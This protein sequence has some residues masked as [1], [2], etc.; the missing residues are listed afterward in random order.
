MK[1]FRLRLAL[2]S[3][4]T[5][6]A[7]LFGAGYYA[8]RLSVRFNLDR[9][10]RELRNLGAAN[11]QRVFGE[12]HWR[13]V[14]SALRFVSGAERPPTYALWVEN[15]GRELYRS[16]HW[17]DEVAIDSLPR[18]AG[19]EG[20]AE[21][22]RPPAPPRPGEPISARNPALPRREPVFLTARAADGT[23]RIAIMGSPYTTLAFAASIDEFNADLGR[24]RLAFLAAVPVALALVGSAAWFFAGRALRPVEALT[25]AAERITV[26]GLDQRLPGEGNDREFQRL[27]TVFNEMLDRLEKSFHQSIRFS[28]DASHEL[29]TPIARLQAELEHAIAVAPAGSAEQQTCTSLLDDVLR[30]KAIVQKLLLLSLADSG[31]LDLHR[32]PIDLSQLVRNVVEDCLQ[33]APALRVEHAIAADVH[34]CGDAVLLEQALQ[35]LTY[36]AIKYNRD[37]GRITCGLSVESGYAKMSVGNTGDGIAEA[38]QARIFD[39][40]FRGDKARARVTTPGSGLGLSLSR[41]ILRGHEGNLELKSSGGDWTEFV[42]SIPVAGRCQSKVLHEP[43]P[44]GA[45]EDRIRAAGRA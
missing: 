28:A 30:L 6:A 29:K 34:V 36:N 24:L 3:G 2:L 15:H 7:L 38:D 39:R 21:F 20:G 41:E 33:L 32:E 27:V 14:E 5:A 18:P 19:Y 45:R 12:E 31:R 9:L 1:S 26:R 23:W 4:T 44:P 16:P 17:P 8:W 25:Q 22:A 40:F 11:L 43:D 37:G 13:R 10:D 35:N 42:A